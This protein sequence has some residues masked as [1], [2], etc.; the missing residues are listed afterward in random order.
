LSI[1]VLEILS[2]VAVI[3][4]VAL[5]LLVRQN[6]RLKA[7]LRRLAE[8]TEDLADRNWELK[9]AEERAINLFE[10][11]E[12]RAAAEAASRAKSRFVAT[13]S[14]EIRTPLNG[15]LGMT[16]LLL[17]TALTPEQ[18]TYTKAVKTSG[19]T[20]LALINEMLDFS[21]IEAGK[22]ELDARP[23]GLTTLV[24]DVV[25]LLA[26]RAQAKGLE[27]ASSVDER[28]PARV[29][30]DATRLR[31]VLLNL[32]GNAVKFTERGG[33]A[34]IVAP[35]ETDHEI[36]FSVRDTG[37]GIA[38]EAHARIFQEF[39]QADG[40]ATRRF[41]GTGLGLAI[42]KRIVERMGG[43]IGVVS[44]PGAGATFTVA[45]P[46]PAAADEMASSTVAVDLSG[47][48]ALIVA[49]SPF[50]VPL[51]A[52]RLKRWGA[53]VTSVDTVTQA[54]MRL[55]ARA[56][57][58]LVVDHALGQADCEELAR[59]SVAVRRRIVL[60]T[61][62]ERSSLPALQE[63]GFTGYLVKPIRAASLAARF[64]PDADGDDGASLVPAD[65]AARTE[66]AG[67]LSILIA[68]DNEIN[69]L[70]ARA[71]LTKLGHVPTV[72]GNGA[73]AV[74]AWS[75]ARTAG[76]PFDLV[77]M[78]VQMPELDGLAATRRI[79][80]VEASAGLAATPIVALTANA[81][82]EDRDACLKAG[83]NGLLMKPL[84]RDR[85]VE[86]LA[87]ARPG[88]IKPVAA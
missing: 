36:K 7:E 84:D 83:M 32:A 2:V 59:A 87:T 16:D 18:T 35:G 40:G 78:D 26:P 9:D 21:K 52:E 68:E 69:A 51:A 80:S 19:E 46:L 10:A 53:D 5:A 37:I 28:L 29:T 38:E 72:V 24:E 63:A 12:A 75:T 31:Q 61:P 66:Q 44:E 64:G 60:V 25:E 57:D 86:A 67:G 82:T 45:V 42:S 23:F 76:R 8:R 58:V 56:F 62:E 14:H 47:Q 85:L 15:I 6:R 88:V 65:H 39:E 3:A 48:A 71:L 41:G 54:R 74:D 73:L 30:G 20:L 81:Y 11:Q 70:L 1:V 79:R 27:I 4:V 50:E 43:R 49:A 34:V 55:T 33:L 17:D 22:L 77:L 13:V